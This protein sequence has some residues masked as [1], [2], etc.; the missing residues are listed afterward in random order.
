VPD[1]L[2]TQVNH[3]ETRLTIKYATMDTIVALI[4]AWLINSLILI[5]S[6]SAFH[7]KDGVQNVEDLKIAY[8]SLNK[9]VYPGMG[10][11]FAIALLAAGQSS[12]IT[13][14]M[15]GQLIMNGFLELTI[16]P[17]IRRLVTRGIAILP[18]LLTVGI[19]GEGGL[20]NL[21]II[22]QVILSF[23]LPFAVVPLVLFTSSPHVMGGAK[24]DL[25]YFLGN[26]ANQ[27]PLNGGEKFANG[28]KL[29]Y[30]SVFIAVIISL[31]NV[32][33]IVSASY[34]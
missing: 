10:T 12:T 4:F 27:V 18:A 8:D 9:F 26:H 15:A 16:Q 29:F 22:S 7:K 23:Q 34:Y 21:L 1:S 20:N 17:W 32:Y 14:T 33:L 5:V 30:T 31:L 3:E 24:L 13:G 19:V 2:G 11:L 25:S 6:A 28:K